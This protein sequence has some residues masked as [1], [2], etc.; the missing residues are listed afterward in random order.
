MQQEQVATKDLRESLK[1]A[2]DAIQ[3]EIEL[4]SVLRGELDTAKAKNKALL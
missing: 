1:T 4:T 3:R 2:R